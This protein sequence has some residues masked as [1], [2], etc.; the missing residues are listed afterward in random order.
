MIRNSKENAEEIEEVMKLG[1]TNRPK[2]ET[3]RVRIP[4]DDL[5]VL[6]SLSW[7]S[8]FML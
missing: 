8:R 1:V 6:C 5:G 4:S 7:K 3:Q 2:S